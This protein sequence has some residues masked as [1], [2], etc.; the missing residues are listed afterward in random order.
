M[1]LN[2]RKIFI[3]KYKYNRIFYNNSLLISFKKMIISNWLIMDS[4]DRHIIKL[5]C[6]NDHLSTALNHAI[7]TGKTSVLGGHF[8][9]TALGRSD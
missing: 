3:A 9:I 1:K 7:K 6:V 4:R 8:K 5:R 2:G